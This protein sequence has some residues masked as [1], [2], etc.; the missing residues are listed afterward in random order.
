MLALALLVCECKSTTSRTTWRRPRARD[1]Q[2][3]TV[4]IVSRGFHRR[5]TAPAAWT[6]PSSAAPS[7]RSA[8][9]DLIRLA[10]CRDRHDTGMKSGLSRSPRGRPSDVASAL[11]CGP[12]FLPSLGLLGGE[13]VVHL[14]WEAGPDR[15]PPLVGQHPVA[16]PVVRPKVARERRER[17]LEAA[18]RDSSG[19]LERAGRHPLVGVVGQLVSTRPMVLLVVVGVFAKRRRSST[20]QRISLVSVSVPSVSTSALARRSRVARNPY[21]AIRCRRGT[22]TPTSSSLAALLSD[23]LSPLR[24]VRLRTEGLCHLTVRLFRVVQVVRVLDYTT[25]RW[26]RACP[27]LPAIEPNKPVPAGVGPGGACAKPSGGR[28]SRSP[29]W[30][31]QALLQWSRCR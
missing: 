10:A 30:S 13:H 27:A 15:W 3:M 28:G 24:A 20:G 9:A 18:T 2:Y 31:R 26:D 16:S 8:T 12:C 14:G 4:L 22:F 17:A 23:I 11:G 25:R 5:Q 21:T 19:C 29:S 7:V 1:R 6:R